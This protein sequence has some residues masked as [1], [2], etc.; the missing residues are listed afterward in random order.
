MRSGDDARRSTDAPTASGTHA[1]RSDEGRRTDGPVEGMGAVP[2]PVLRTLG[3]SVAR[4]IRRVCEGWPASRLEAR[5]RDVVRFKWRHAREEALAEALAEARRLE[6]RL[7]ELQARRLDHGRR[8][9][10]STATGE[11]R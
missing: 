6:A 7:L 4:R 11:T 10:R 5:I 1:S 2:E 9:D 8:D 3:A